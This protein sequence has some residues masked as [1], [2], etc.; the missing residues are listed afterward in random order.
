[1]IF[2]GSFVTMVTSPSHTFTIDFDSSDLAIP[3]TGTMLNNEYSYNVNVDANS[4]ATFTVNVTS[5]TGNPDMVIVMVDPNSGAF[6]A[7]DDAKTLELGENTVDWGP[8]GDPVGLKYM[9]RVD[10]DDSVTFDSFIATDGSG[11]SGSGDSGSGD[12]G[13]GSST[14]SGISV[15][16][17]VSINFNDGVTG[18]TDVA[19]IGS[20]AGENQ[21]GYAMDVAAGGSVTFD[22]NATAITGDPRMQITMWNGANPTEYWAA[23]DSVDL[24]T[25]LNSLS[26]GPFDSNVHLKFLILLDSDDTVSLD[27]YV[28]SD[29]SGSSG[30]GGS[31]TNG[32]RFVFESES[33]GNPAYDF[34]TNSVEIT[35]NTSQAYSITIPA[36]TDTGSGNTFSS[37]LLYAIG[38]DQPIVVSDVTLTVDG[39][40]YGGSGAN[41]LLFNNI[42]GGVDIDEDSFTYTFLSTSQSWGGFALS[43]AQANSLPTSGLVFD[44]DATLTFSAYLS[45]G[46]VNLPPEYDGET[47]FSNGSIDTSE[48]TGTGRDGDA[49]YRWS[50]YTTWFELATGDTQGGWAGG[51]NWSWLSDLPA[52]WDNGVI[53]LGPD[54]IL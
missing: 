53:T 24:A 38:A 42:F 2:L 50:A 32:V 47:A 10:A 36:Y 16:D 15:T 27:S 46:A 52:T 28:V 43:T 44:S 21:Y 7:I 1:M 29:G 20:H 9:I 18:T 5:V 11:S 35:G 37:M 45:D 12:S 8:F 25:G 31:V 17:A 4:S 3:Y 26:W 40:T 34:E 49:P 6:W 23:S 22:V 51:D 33:G 13:S 41:S 19:Y 48:D 30:G 39:V 54:C 14:D